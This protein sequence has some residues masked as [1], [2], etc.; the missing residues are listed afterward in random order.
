[1]GADLHLW[2]KP[3]PDARSPRHFARRVPDV[4]R[5][6]EHFRTHGGAL[7]ETG[8]TPHCD[9]FFVFDPGSKLFSGWNLMTLPQ[10]ALRN[11]I[12]KNYFVLGWHR[13]RG[14]L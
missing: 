11:S 12:R 8:P 4:N 13:L 7:Q 5:A 3:A 2:Q 10:V 14:E 9:R 6:R 1:V